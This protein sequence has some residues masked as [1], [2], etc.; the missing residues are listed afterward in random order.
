MSGAT[1]IVSGLQTYS[2]NDRVLRL[3]DR[4][5]GRSL[6]E[7]RAIVRGNE[8][9]R[10]EGVGDD[11]L[12]F[13][14]RELRVIGLESEVAPLDATT[15][16]LTVYDP[17]RRVLDGIRHELN[18][19]KKRVDELDFRFT[20]RIAADISE[21]VQ[22]VSP[23]LEPQPLPVP[24]AG[25]SG[26]ESWIGRI[27]LNVVGIFTLVLGIAFLI[28]YAAREIL[29]SPFGR[30]GIGAALSVGLVAGGRYL[31]SRPGFRHFALTIMGGGWAGIYAVVYA[32]HMVPS[33]MFIKDPIVGSVCLLAV[34]AAI[35][36]ESLRFGSPFF[37]AIGTL[38]GFVTM[39]M[40]P[41]SLFTVVMAVAFASAAAFI[42]YQRRWPG[43]ALLSMAGS[44]LSFIN[45]SGSQADSL[46]LTTYTLMLGAQWLVFTVLPVI[47][48][49]RYED[50][51][52]ATHA[53]SVANAAAFTILFA[54][55]AVSRHFEFTWLVLLTIAG[56]YSLRKGLLMMWGKERVDEGVDGI[57]AVALTTYAGVVQFT[58]LSELFFLAIEACVLIEIAYRLGDK[59]YRLAG[60]FVSFWTLFEYLWQP[61][62]SD[63]ERLIV[64]LGI[65]ILL[66]GYACYNRRRRIELPV[67]D[68]VA[69]I[70]LVLAAVSTVHHRW[71]S[72][73]WGAE[74]LLFIV[75]GLYMRQ[76][77]YRYGGLI[78]FC[79]VLTK[80]F[81]IDTLG[82]PI[83]FKILSF[84]GLGLVLLA[85]S[86][87]Y[88]RLSSSLE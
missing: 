78:L 15:V 81:L 19:L 86:Y 37:L 6:E 55:E 84:I 74:A 4:V 41:A 73:I 83:V 10:F 80:L 50:M 57:L 31:Y 1:V 44:Y 9:V 72:L 13:I 58:G 27:G 85:A 61:W 65:G 3:F 87:V 14:C 11:D 16:S 8:Q 28:G 88:T 54:S 66:A 71:Y 62:G 82:L 43:I 33:V 18:D 38:L 67:L 56:L 30:L 34:V 79:V 32:A 40:H 2:S 22:P 45:W 25:D 35:V 59:R 47:R 68:V 75:T 70:V 48:I 52:Q 60:F 12:E 49:S 39:N 7:R 42:G 63:Y 26:V 76:P 17:D 64:G 24:Q 69:M 53:F 20:G 46:S 23:V 77:Q 51:K 29:F 36:Y 21:P 5:S